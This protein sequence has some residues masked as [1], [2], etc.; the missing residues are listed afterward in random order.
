[1]FQSQIVE[2]GLM[3]CTGRLIKVG[4]FIKERTARLL[5]SP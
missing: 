1:M 2:C 3:L 5:K 4:V